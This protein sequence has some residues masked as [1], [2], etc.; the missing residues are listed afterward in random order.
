MKSKPNS[1]SPAIPILFWGDAAELSKQNRSSLFVLAWRFLLDMGFS[2]PIHM[3]TCFTEQA[4]AKGR[5]LEHN[6]NSMIWRWVS[7]LLQALYHGHHPTTDMHG[8]PWP[9]GIFEAE[10]AG[11]QLCRGKVFGVAW[12]ITAVWEFLAQEFGLPS[13]AK[14]AFC[15]QCRANKYSEVLIYCKVM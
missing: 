2:L 8:D 4:F 14:S 5:S 15:W 3:L 9:Q 7:F 12:A 13:H 1:K 6:T 10:H 11:K